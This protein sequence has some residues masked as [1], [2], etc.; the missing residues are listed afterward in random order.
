MSIS[1]SSLT[2]SSTSSAPS[3]SCNHLLSLARRQQTATISRVEAMLR[4]YHPGQAG[5]GSSAVPL[6]LRPLSHSLLVPFR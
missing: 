3:S 5:G 6:S 4:T 1:A 2:P